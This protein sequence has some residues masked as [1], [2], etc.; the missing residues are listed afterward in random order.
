ME[1]SIA[2]GVRAIEESMSGSKEAAL[3]CVADSMRL[4][5]LA[6]K[7]IEIAEKYETEEPQKSVEIRE[8]DIDLDNVIQLKKAD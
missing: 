4:A 3:E 1:K 5:A 2:L 8:S 6:K 7:L